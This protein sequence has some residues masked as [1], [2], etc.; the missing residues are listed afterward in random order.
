M[1]IGGENWLIPVDAQLRRDTDAENEAISLRS[2]MLQVSNSSQV[3]VVILDACRNNPFAN[4]MQ[5]TIRV[6]SVDR[7]LNRV[8]PTDNVLV[9]YAAR[10][11]TTANDGDGRNS[12][13]TSALLKNI[14]TP[15]LEIRF[16]F[17]SVRDDVLASTK[18]QQQPFVYGSLSKDLIFLKP[19]QLTMPISRS[20]DEIGWDFLKDT[21]DAASLRR[22]VDQFPNSSHRTEAENRIAILATRLSPTSS[23]IQEVVP[24]P[25]EPLR[26]SKGDGGRCSNFNGERV[27]D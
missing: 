13:F 3:G 8:D 9:A 23:P 6:R 21:T 25:R 10:D 17:A 12:P 15:G 22:F 24:K 14:E 4:S 27:C 26:Q 20:A 2:V 1:E 5:R 16:M 19:G 7:G 18:R 11:G